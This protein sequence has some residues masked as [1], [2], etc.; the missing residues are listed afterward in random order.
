METTTKTVASLYKKA[1]TMGVEDHSCKH[2]PIPRDTFYE[3]FTLDDEL[4]ISLSE[5]YE[6]YR[7]GYRQG[8]PIKTNSFELDD[9]KQISYAIKLDYIKADPRFTMASSSG[10]VFKSFTAQSIDVAYLYT[11]KY[12]ENGGD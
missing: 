1:H 6:V 12:L 9:L 3:M 2:L 11:Q 7:K 4:L 10:Y 8:A 5:L